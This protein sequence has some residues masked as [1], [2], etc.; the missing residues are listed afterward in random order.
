DFH[1]A[2]LGLPT[3]E[4]RR[5]DPVLAAHLGGRKPGLLLAQHRNDLLFREP[6]SLHRPVLPSGR[7]LASSGGNNGGHSRY[8]GGYDAIRRYARSWAKLNASETADAFV[9]LTFAPGEAYQF[10]W[11][12]EI[13]VMDG[14][15]TIVKVAHL[16]LC[17]SRMMF[18]RVYPRETQEMVFDAH[19]RAFAF[20]KGACGRGVYDNMK[21]A[22][23]T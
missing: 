4:R 20:F 7:T 6:R 14:V 13:V 5:A 18:V 2:K 12:H 17:H 11:S 15:T 16:R 8:D 21:T 10:D 9:P 19:E 1:P 22:V 3:V 23:E